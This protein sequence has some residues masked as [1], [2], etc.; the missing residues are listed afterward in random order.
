MLTP[1][2]QRL[3]IPTYVLLILMGLFLVGCAVGL[4][5][6][7]S[8]ASIQL[9]SSIPPIHIIQVTSSQINEMDITTYME[10]Q[11]RL[12]N[13]GFTPLIQM[14]V[15]QLPSPN[16]FDVGMKP[17]A[18]TYC[19]IL[20]VP[21]QITPQLSFVT[22]FS[23]GVWYSTNA[24]R[25]NNKELDYLISEY[26]PNSSPDQLYIQHIQGIAQ[27]KQQRDWQL[28]QVLNLN[29]YMAAL[30]DHLR[31]YLVTYNVQSFKA[32]FNLWH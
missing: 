32:E 1:L 27:Y 28:P 15:P 7:A 9:I 21:G 3:K 10:L 29:R 5:I 14:T 26:Y 25:G 16:F 19:E 18:G 13:L 2:A 8:P 20:K 22:V 23:N 31:W 6:L 11:S 4:K 24:W 30:S 12:K 17:E